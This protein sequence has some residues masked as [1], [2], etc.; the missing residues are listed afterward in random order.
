MMVRE[1]IKTESGRTV[2][3][4]HFESMTD[5]ADFIETP[6]IAA[7]VKQR[8]LDY[9]RDNWLGGKRAETLRRL[10]DGGDESLA[11][12]TPVHFD[13]ISPETCAYSIAQT[14]GPGVP[15]IPAYLAGVPDWRCEV[16]ETAGSGPLRIWVDTGMVANIRVDQAL[17]RA[18]AVFTLAKTL[19]ATRPVSVRLKNLLHGKE[20]FM[21]RRLIGII[22]AARQ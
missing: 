7:I 12:S 4:V 5:F 18:G 2:T 22:H 13:D 20:C 6:K 1:T 21:I 8:F 11:E 3:R 16:I 10:R 15:L 14:P 17:Q 19:S 9:T